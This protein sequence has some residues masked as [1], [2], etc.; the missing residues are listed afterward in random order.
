MIPPRIHLNGTSKQELLGNAEI[1]CRAVNEAIS[2]LRQVYPNGR[3]YYPQRDSSALQKAAHQHCEM[4]RKLLAVQE[5]LDALC[6]D[7][8]NGGQSDAV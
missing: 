4:I 3:D 6:L 2:K 8:S 7:I 5:E 1:A